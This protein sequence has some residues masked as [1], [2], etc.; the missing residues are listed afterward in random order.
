VPR[1]FWSSRACHSNPRSRGSGFDPSAMAR[2]VGGS[3]ADNPTPRPIR[4]K[5]VL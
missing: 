5:S 4:T 2:G 3:P 1:F